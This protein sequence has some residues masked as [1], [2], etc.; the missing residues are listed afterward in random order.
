MTEALK[1]K[2]SREEELKDLIVEF[3]DLLEKENLEDNF[4]NRKKLFGMFLE[5][6]R[7]PLTE[8]DIKYLEEKVLLKKE[9]KMKLK[10]PLDVKKE[11]RPWFPADKEE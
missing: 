11:H 7:E 10:S 1:E 8:Q 4:E 5:N 2:R 6:T 3:Y 9:K